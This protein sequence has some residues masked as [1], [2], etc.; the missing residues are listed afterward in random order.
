MV[1]KLSA[2]IFS[3]KSEIGKEERKVKKGKQVQ[4]ALNADNP[5]ATIASGKETLSE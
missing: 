1:Q 5:I 2:E 3:H 4:K